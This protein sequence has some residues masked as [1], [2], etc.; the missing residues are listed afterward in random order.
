MA[1]QPHVDR[2]PVDV[3]VGAKVKML[4]K[5]HRL[6]QQGLAARLGVSFQQVQKYEKGA[7]RISAAMLYRIAGLFALPIGAMFEGLPAEPDAPAEGAADS[8]GSGLA[9]L[10]GTAGGRGLTEAFLRMPP[11]SRALLIDI[12]EAM[13]R[14]ADLHAAPDPDRAP[15]AT[16]RVSQPVQAPARGPT[17]PR[18][19]PPLALSTA[20]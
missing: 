13:I 15:A 3:F 18:S 4:R 17:S 19:R 12:A 8:A 16:P 7:N 20:S 11:A 5:L 1:S 2:D 14:A 10:I 6:S 9:A